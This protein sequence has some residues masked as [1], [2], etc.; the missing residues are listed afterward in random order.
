MLELDHTSG[1]GWHCRPGQHGLWNHPYW[2]GLGSCV[3]L[4]WIPSAQG[5]RQ[6][7]AGLLPPGTSGTCR[8]P[9]RARITYWGQRLLESS[10]CLCGS[11]KQEVQVTGLRALWIPTIPQTHL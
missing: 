6:P 11:T 5:W 3:G 8:T 4:G 9:F 7:A 1:A 2:L 10:S